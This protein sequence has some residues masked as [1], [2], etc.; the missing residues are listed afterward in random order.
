MTDAITPT[1]AS[2]SLWS[3]LEGVSATLLSDCDD[4]AALREAAAGLHALCASIARIAK[5][6][7]ASH[8][9]GTFLSCGQAISPE[10][11]A[12]CVLDHRRTS[13][14]VRGLFAAIRQAQVCFPG[15]AIE[16]L[17]AGCGPFAPLALP[18]ATQF[19]PH[20]L[21]FTL[22]DIHQPSLDAARRIFHAV[23]ADAWLRGCIRCD[24][25]SYRRED[26]LPIH[27]VIAEAMQAALDKEPQ[28]AITANLAPQLAAGG[29]LVPEK[30][31]VSA[32]L[33][34]LRSE[35]AMPHFEVGEAVS[36]PNR[37]DLGPIVK[38]TANATAP[39]PRRIVIPADLD[40]ERYLSL[41]TT[42]Q[43]FGAIKLDDGESGLT[44]LK[45]LLA[46]GQVQSG[47]TYEFTYGMGA[48]PGLTV[49]R[50]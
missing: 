40:G 30:I 45:P 10:D 21:Q 50:A 9:D 48:R 28:V 44:L 20:E 37:R 12:R 24:A 27:V 4:D 14:F 32:C 22:L 31:T 41:A 8:S 36:A 47:V 18:V 15:V 25:A 3:R 46:L 33:C 35:F 16:V 7:E 43:V 49:R 23:G 11:A 13:K 6:P 1:T 29:I 26:D 2:R 17:Y 39:T 38:L 5:T 42:I 34:E 19:R